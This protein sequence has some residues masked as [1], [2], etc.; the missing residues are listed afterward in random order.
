MNFIKCFD[1]CLLIRLYQTQ[2]Y[3]CFDFFVCKFF[4]ICFL[5][6]KRFEEHKAGSTIFI[7]LGSGEF[8]IPR[9]CLITTKIWSNWPAIQLSDGPVLQL[10]VTAQFYLESKGKYILEAW[11]HAH[12][13]DLKR[14][15][16][17][18]FWLLFLC[19]PLLLDPPYVNG[20]SQE[21]RLFHLRSSL[22]SSDLLCSVS[23][24]FS[25]L[26]LLATTILDPL[27]LF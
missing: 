9:F 20:A 7:T 25:L 14:G 6:T 11:G 3:V 15:P 16:W 1:V 26:R 17:V 23:V 22:W 18:H 10:C 27:F 5:K 24:G 21:C 2:S 19:F 8:A 4:L 12:P 13:K